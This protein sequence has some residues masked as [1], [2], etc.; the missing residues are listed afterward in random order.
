MTE[1][2]SPH[3]DNDFERICGAYSRFD[4]KVTEFDFLQP[5]RE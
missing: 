1:F 2:D 4:G 3:P 5:H